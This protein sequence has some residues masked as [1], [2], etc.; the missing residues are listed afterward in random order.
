MVQ[1]DYAILIA[2]KPNPKSYTELKK[3]VRI[4]RPVLL[5]HLKRLQKKGLIERDIDTRE[6]KLSKNYVYKKILSNFDE[7]QKLSDILLPILEEEEKITQLTDIKDQFKELSGLLGRELVKLQFGLISLFKK[8]LEQ[9]EYGKAQLL[10]EEVSVN[11]ITP[12]MVFLFYALWQKKDVALSLLD[13]ELEIVSK[14]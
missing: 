14:K 13:K 1:S 11:V 5:R 9:E 10:V 3:E 12:W 8:A 6:Y 2:L 7:L 4:S